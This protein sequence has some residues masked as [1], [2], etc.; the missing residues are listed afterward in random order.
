MVHLHAVGVDVLQTAAFLRI[1]RWN[2]LHRP[3][4]VHLHGPLRDVEVVRAHVGQSATGIL[5]VVP[6]GREVLVYSLGAKGFVITA[7][8]GWPEPAIP[9]GSGG[10]FLCGQVASDGRVANTDADRLQLADATVPDV[11]HG[12]AEVPAELGALLAPGL[13]GHLRRLHGV[14][15]GPAF[16]H[17]VREWLF[18]VDVLARLGCCD[19]RNR[20]P[21]VRRGDQHGIQA[22][23]V[24][25]FFVL[26]VTL[27]PGVGAGLG[28]LGVLLRHHLHGVVDP[29]LDHIAHRHHFHIGSAQQ[30]TQM[31]TAHGA[32]TDETH[33]DLV[34]SRC[35]R[36]RLCPKERG[37]GSE[38]STAQKRATS[39]HE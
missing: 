35:P 30:S 25:Q 17:V 28:A 34:G 24:E 2:N 39:L 16:G 6:P 27:H 7:F 9:V 18:A 15:D 31:P 11:L 14:G 4:A 5:A 21:V 19:A 37:S 33:G 22:L 3:A 13:E 20:M 36:R 10:H 12:L 29:L 26:D 1:V 38:R 8:R 23:V 32:H